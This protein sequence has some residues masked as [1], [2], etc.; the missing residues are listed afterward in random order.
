MIKIT[1]PTMTLSGIAASNDPSAPVVARVVTWLK[2]G[3]DSAGVDICNAETQAMLNAMVG[4]LDATSVATVIA[5][6]KETVLKYP[7]LQ[8]THVE[9]ARAMQ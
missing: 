3:A 6:S 2:P 7:G 1:Q 5:L 8:Q 4:V 9:K